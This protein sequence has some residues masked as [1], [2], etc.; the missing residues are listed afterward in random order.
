V[1]L[2][3]LLTGRVPG[4]ALIGAIAVLILAGCASDGSVSNPFERRATWVDYIS[5]GDIRRGCE[6]GDPAA[7]GVYRFV[8]YRDRLDQVRLYD[9]RS[10]AEA[11]DGALL[12]AHVLTGSTAVHRWR[13]FED[14]LQPWR[15]DITEAPV[16]VET[17]AAIRADA[18]A[19]GLAVRPPPEGRVLASR[20]YFWL[21]SACL[22][23]EGFA[24][25]IWEWPDED[26]RT[27]RFAE[28]LHAADATG[29]GL[30]RP[31]AQEERLRNPSVSRAWEPDRADSVFPD[32]DLIVTPNGVRMGQSYYRHNR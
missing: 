2:G 14:P 26:Y 12:R 4:R 24:F 17:A 32:Y 11:S 10:P 6:A 23:D 29:V 5:G 31:P 9:L 22:P 18:R 19:G 25:Q 28:L 1:R 8:E 16:D 3:S 13:L 30:N 20:S 27:R 15:G 21:V 7:Q